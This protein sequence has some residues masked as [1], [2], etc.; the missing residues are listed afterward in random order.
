MRGPSVTSSGTVSTTTRWHSIDD[1]LRTGDCA[2]EQ[3]W[4]SD[5]VDAL[6]RITTGGES[7]YPD[8]IEEVLRQYPAF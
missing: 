1:W 6:D 7:V 8:E 2:G 5:I 3:R 4:L